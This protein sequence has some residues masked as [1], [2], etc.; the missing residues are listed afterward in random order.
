MQSAQWKYREVENEVRQLAHTLP[1]GARLPTEHSLAATFDCH[2]LTIRKAL[3]SLVAEG[4]IV[5]RAGSGTFVAPGAVSKPAGRSDRNENRIGLLVHDHSNAYAYRLLRGLSH[6]ALESNLDLRPAWI[7]DLP[8][9]G[10]KQAE[11][12][13]KDGCGSLIVPWYPHHLTDEV[14]AFVQAAPLPTAIPVVIPGFEK[15]YYGNPNTYGDV[16]LRTT[17]ALCRYFQLLG[18]SKI[19]LLGPESAEDPILQKTL[20]SYICY[21]S[22]QKLPHLCGIVSSESKAMDQLA[23]QWKEFAGD[24]AVI[25]YDDEHALRFMTSMHK[26]GLVAPDDYLIVGHN[27]TEASRFSDPPLSTLCQDFEYIGRWLLKNALAL[28]RDSVDQDQGS[29]PQ[30]LIVRGTCGG[31]GRITEQLKHKLPELQFIEE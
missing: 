3:K 18:R 5:R 26:L 30:K 11:V 19:A 20:S 22:A 2:V 25:S 28:S 14:R 29:M 6:A 13:A 27:D 31:K 24:L 15:N 1:V 8:A 12:F 10:L 7:R 16:L 9:D 17:E 4:L 23:A 21:I